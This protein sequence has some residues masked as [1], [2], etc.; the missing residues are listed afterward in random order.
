MNRLPFTARCLQQGRQTAL[1][2][3]PST[4]TGRGRGR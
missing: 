1:S 2:G 4:T 3:W